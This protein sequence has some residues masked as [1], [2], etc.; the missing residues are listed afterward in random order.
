[1]EHFIGVLGKSEL[2]RPLCLAT[3]FVT[4]AGPALWLGLAEYEKRTGRLQRALGSRMGCVR[5]LA[6]VEVGMA[7]LRLALFALTISTTTTFWQAGENFGAQMVIQHVGVLLFTAGVLLMALGVSNLG[8]EG[9]FFGDYCGIYLNHECSYPP[10]NL[11]AHPQYSGEV[12]V[13]LSLALL[14]GS[15]AGLLLSVWLGLCYAVAGHLE[16]RHTRYVYSW[17]RKGKQVV[18][19]E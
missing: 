11:L 9:T 10:N 16:R 19:F 5:L 13:H 8:F 7:V 1:M 3:A 4:S 12:L 17:K 14:Q 15:P 18:S 2:Q 6:G